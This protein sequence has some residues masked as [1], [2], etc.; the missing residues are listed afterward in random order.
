MVKIFGFAIR[1]VVKP[2]VRLA[3]LCPSDECMLM[4]LVSLANKSRGILGQPIRVIARELLSLD[5]FDLGAPNKAYEA[6]KLASR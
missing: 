6:Q 3:N 2:F 4:K 5:R 1:L